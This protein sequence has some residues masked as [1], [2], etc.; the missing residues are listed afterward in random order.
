[1]YIKNIEIQNF[2]Q[3]IKEEINLDR[4]ITYLAGANNS[5]KTSIVDFVKHV[6]VGKTNKLALEDFPIKSVREMKRKIE[7]YLITHNNSIDST[8]LKEKLVEFSDNETSKIGLNLE[9]GYDEEDNISA[10][11]DYLMDLDE[12]NK[13]FYFRYEFKCDIDSFM[14]SI[15]EKEE[16]IKVG[17]F[18]KDEIT[19]LFIKNFQENFY[20]TD[21]NYDLKEKM[22]PSSFRELFHFQSI[23]ANK[24]LTDDKIEDKYSVGNSILHLLNM[25]DDWDEVIQSI[26]EKLKEMMKS[27]K[28]LESKV[29]FE[30]TKKLKQTL[31]ELK[32]TNGGI[33]ENIQ[34]MF[35]LNEDTI[36]S[37]LKLIIKAKYDLKDLKLRENSQ[38]LG[39]SNLIYLH[40]QLE[41]FMREKK[42]NESK[43]NIFIIEEPEAHM[44]PQM[45]RT[46]INYLQKHYLENNLQGVVTTHSSD[47]I[48]ITRYPLIRVIRKGNEDGETGKLFES[49]IY[50]LYKFKREIES[51]IDLKRFYERF[52]NL[53]LSE[54][55]FADRAILYEGDTERMYIQTIIDMPLI[56]EGRVSTNYE[57]L[58]KLYIAYI[59]VGGAYAHKYKEII[60]FL[61]IKSV[62]F[63]DID[64]G[65]DCM[66]EKDIL[67]SKTSN[68]A[69]VEYYYDYYG[70]NKSEKEE[71]L[72]KELFKWK[73]ER[74]NDEEL[75][76]VQFQDKEDYYSRTL[77]EAMILKLLKEPVNITKKPKE[78]RDFRK[79][80]NL[81]ISIPRRKEKK[82]VTE[83][84]DIDIRDILSSTSNGKTNFMYSVIENNKMIET[85]PIYIEDGLKWLKK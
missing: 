8:E 37:F 83:N 38:G 40:L 64:Y 74:N 84:C 77:E 35:D 31:N 58:S 56:L 11:A 82:K 39:Y 25:D 57:Q 28:M 48:K 70:Y 81:K 30:S 69:L 41:S 53:N 3:F 65:K 12:N 47:I 68:S 71:V 7:E 43:V 50:D 73:S 62:I 75:I 23:S 27:E 76:L 78:W 6:L 9:I 72:I 45:Q 59:Q 22:T 20:Y 29:K 51:D 49:K 85:M 10:F 61:Q 1:M 80:T 2:R 4:N 63:T 44:H 54:L 33:E 60:K 34:L 14:K 79:S 42:N 17:N 66:E 26:Q 46:F 52:F 32:K 36:N 13:S 16:E 67:E 18:T 19:D 21:R 15:I 5:G 55:I 24:R